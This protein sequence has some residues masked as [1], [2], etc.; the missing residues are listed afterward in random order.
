MA[1]LARLLGHIIASGGDAAKAAEKFAATGPSLTN[2]VGLGP[3]RV[4]L[5]VDPDVARR[6]LV[7]EAD[8]A[9]KLA[10]E[11]H[12]LG[13]VMR[14]GLILLEGQAWAQR[15][16]AVASAFAS[17]LMPDVLETTR[18]VTG[19]RLASW[20]GRVNISHEARC[21]IYDLMLRFFAGGTAVGE[22]PDEQSTDAY[23]R[24]FACAEQALERRIWD[25]LNLHER[26]KRMTGRSSDLGDE[27]AWRRPLRRRIAAGQRCPI[28]GR[29]ALERLCAHLSS[30]DTVYHELTTEVAAGA[31]SIHHLA[32][33]CQLLATRPD[34]QERLFDEIEARQE[35]TASPRPSATER[36][37]A[38]LESSPYL[39]AVIKESLRLYPPAPFL[40]R[41][42]RDRYAMVVSIWGMH[43]HPRFWD[44]PGEFAPERWLGVNADPRAYMPFGLGPRTCIGRRFALIESRAALVEILRRFEL[45]PAGPV[46]RPRLYIM[47]RPSR[48]I[49]VH[50]VPRAMVC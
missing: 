1:N 38:E 44:Q 42:G 32:W 34:I 47:T 14:D 4:R 45:K 25:P 41:R 5:T 40:Y 37:L 11:H 12:V 48:D 22:G 26:I 36:D 50:V 15:R 18:R 7:T 46:P 6:L 16:Q 9:H 10:L 21:L 8:E 13:P 35:G 3:L 29:G 24:H 31:T 20:S 30:T 49:L 28:G 2:D 19:A 33:T 27:A 23:G 39:S 17:E 43:R